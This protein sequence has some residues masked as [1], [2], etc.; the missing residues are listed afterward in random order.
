MKLKSARTRMFRNILDSTPVAFDES[1]T[2][3]VGKNESGKSSFLTALA[4]LNPARR[5]GNFE[6]HAD[7]PAWLEKKH[8]QAGQDLGSCARV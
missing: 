7:Y 8:R 2:A 3:I 5:V 1:V 4:R 6:T